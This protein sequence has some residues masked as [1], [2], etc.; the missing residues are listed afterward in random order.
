MVAID[1]MPG[2]DRPSAARDVPILSSPQPLWD[3]SLVPQQSGITGAEGL[4]GG[5]PKLTKMAISPRLG[6]TP[7]RSL[8]L[9]MG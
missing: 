1:R 6:T 2:A 3:N 9:Q 4:A 7:E 8:A 5:L